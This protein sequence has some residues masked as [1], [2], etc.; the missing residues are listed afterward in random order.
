MSEGVARGTNDANADDDDDEDDDNA[1]V[2]EALRA[3][4]CVR[5]RPSVF[6]IISSADTSS[7]AFGNC[8][9]L[10]RSVLKCRANALARSHC[11]AEP[12]HPATASGVT[13]VPG[14]VRQA[15]FTISA[16]R[17]WSASVRTCTE[18][19]FGAL[20]VRRRGCK[21]FRIVRASRSSSVCDGPVK[22]ATCRRQGGLSEK[23]TT[24]ALAS[25]MNKVVLTS[26]AQ[27]DSRRRRRPT[28]RLK[29]VNSPR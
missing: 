3:G 26:S 19:P 14:E 17:R 6:N 11:R 9:P 1:S 18:A 21:P 16:N 8:T 12:R 7:A 29:D 27:V 5:S 2:G 22:P 25:S 24:A 23:F 13:A 10:A 20:C 28:A 15:A 4:A